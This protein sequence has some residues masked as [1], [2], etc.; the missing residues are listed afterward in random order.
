MREIVYFY[1]VSEYS[2]S[3]NL[4]VFLSFLSTYPPSKQKMF[5]VFFYLLSYLFYFCSYEISLL[6]NHNTLPTI[7]LPV[8][9]C[10]YLF[11]M[12]LDPI[13]SKSPEH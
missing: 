4:I 12:P 2:V 6:K 10:R 8:L 5:C 11:L 3:F 13:S 9:N 1:Q 7:S